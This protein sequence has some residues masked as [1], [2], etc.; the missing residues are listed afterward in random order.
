MA[1]LLDQATG[2]GK[3]DTLLADTGYNNAGMI[4]LAR[5]AASSSGAGRPHAAGQPDHD[6]AVRHAAAEDRSSTTG[7]RQLSLSGGHD[8]GRSR[9]TAEYTEYGG[10]P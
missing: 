7:K 2:H 8:L 4:A 6:Q 9:Q 10:A 3:V 1:G 5:R